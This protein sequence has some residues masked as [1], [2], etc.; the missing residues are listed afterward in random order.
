ME[1]T[2]KLL[3]E[4]SVL[5]LLEE[6]DQKNILEEYKNE[7][8]TRE[9]RNIFLAQINNLERIYPGG[10]R[11]Y[12]KRAKVL[13]NNSKNNINPFAR[14]KPSVPNGTK[15]NIGDDNFYNLE[16]VGLKELKN[17]AFV[18]VA[19]GLGERL[20][21][22]DIKIGIATE[23]I[24]KRVYFNVYA[25]YLL[26]YQDR[27]R[28]MHRID[29]KDDW[30]IPLC[31]MTSDDTHEGT[32]KLL[33]EHNYFGLKEEQINIVKQDKVPAILD[34]DCHFA[35]VKDELI[36]DT[37]PH[38]H[39]D[40]HT[41][42]LHS[43]VVEK[44]HKLGKK[45]IIFFQDTNALIF[46]AVPSFLGVSATNNFVV[47]T[48]T[49][50]RKP[51]EAV[52]G[53]C[54]LTDEETNSSIT[55]N[56]EYNQLDSLLRDK[57]NPNGDVANE[58]GLSHFPGNTNV[59]LFEVSSY[60]ET[61]LR[62]NGLM[63][64]FVNPKY[65]DE[66]KNLF[67]SATRLEC[68]MQ[69]YPR[70]LEKDEKVGFTMYD[71]WFCFSTC[72][73]N[74]KDGIDKLK[75]NL[76]PETAF[77]VEQ[78]IYNTNRIILSDILHKLEVTPGV[79]SDVEVLGVKVEFGPRIV[80]YP[81]FA[82]TLAELSEKIEGKIKISEDSTLVVKGSD[83]KIVNLE[84]EGFLSVENEKVEGSLKNSIRYK[85]VELSEGEGENYEKIRGYTIKVIDS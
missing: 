67:K 74:L 27:V 12:I 4:V 7:K 42:L 44:W 34:N 80:F 69:D 9:D 62:T 31:I 5:K 54:M 46:I 63:P 82:V 55:I 13:L 53:L 79:K 24:T 18:L 21:Y 45:W 14:Y 35:L 83:S 2:R 33:K 39:G 50:P 36:I 85:F 43:R 76:N 56:V 25:D 84:L 30:C 19:G 65:A 8:Y 47:N 81:S 60:Y 11:E 51:G 61:L 10:L 22:N 26:A 72:K 16:L 3:D 17:S 20:G 37:K 29:E 71:K 49:I 77:S 1:S 64:E 23:L 15:I 75:K 57:W 6:L 38:G 58:Q 32:L 73:N 78:D 68:M 48:V 40:I 66:G 41:L 52:G 59:L 28:K 70:L